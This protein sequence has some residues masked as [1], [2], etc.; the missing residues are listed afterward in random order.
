MKVTLSN[1]GPISRAEIEL[2]DLTVLVG[3]QATGKSIFLATFKLLQ[4]AGAIADRFLKFDLIWSDNY[5]RF[6]DLYFGEGL[7]GIW[8]EK[9]AVYVNGSPVTLEELLQSAEKKE[10][11]FYIPAQRVLTLRDG[12]TRPFGEYR[13]EDPFVMRQFSDILH[14]LVQAEFARHDLLFPQPGRLKEAFRDLLDKHIFRGFTL[15]A[16][17]KWGP[18]RLVL[19]QSDGKKRLPFT[20]WSA[21]QREFVPL[22]LGLYWLMP[23]GHVSRRRSIE[24]VIVEEPEMGLHPYAVH[25]M[26]MLLLDLLRRGYRLLLS[27]H[28]LAVLDIVWALQVFKQYKDEDAVLKLAGWPRRGEYYKLARCALE[29]TYRVFYFPPEGDVLDI[30][31]LHPGDEDIHVAGWGGL[32]EFSGYVADLVAEVI[33]RHEAKEHQEN[34]DE[35]LH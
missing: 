30:S 5:A 12:L 11:V 20:V 22:L 3:P 17:R 31:S 1:F 29:K 7:G 4:D 27:T 34:T 33:E 13:V 9:G 23:A 2:G 15:Q 16:D 32:S 21:G 6:L 14:R 28:S 18:R 8:G 19:V 25:G 35:V 24:W 26:M 10:R